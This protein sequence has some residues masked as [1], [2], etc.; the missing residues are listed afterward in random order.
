M[1]YDEKLPG[2]YDKVLAIESLKHSQNLAET[3]NNLLGSLTDGGTMII[4]DDFMTADSVNAKKHMDLW[5]AHSFTTIECLIDIIGDCGDFDMDAHDMTK[6]VP[7]KSSTM[8]QFA[9]KMVDA[10]FVFSF[11]RMKRNLKTY[12]GA[13]LLE[14]LYKKK[15]AKYLI[16]IIKKKE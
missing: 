8:L 9:N 2:L 11:N 1:N 15:Q 5:Q 6:L 12:K 14:G 16:L 10:A 7:T 4:A 13:L 3:L